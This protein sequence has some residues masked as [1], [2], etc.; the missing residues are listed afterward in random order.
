MHKLQSEIVK[1]KSIEGEIIEMDI[2]AAKY[3]KTLNEMIDSLGLGEEDDEP[4]PVPINTAT[5]N[6]V[7]SMNCQVSYLI[8]E[9]VNRLWSG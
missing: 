9:N 8:Y 7:N 2:D 4:V 3:C 6:K 1:L 5:L